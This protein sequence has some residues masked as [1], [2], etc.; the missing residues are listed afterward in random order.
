MIKNLGQRLFFMIKPASLLIYFL[1][2]LISSCDQIEEKKVNIKV[3]TELT[4]ANPF[5]L[6]EEWD[7]YG[8]GD[9]YVLRHNGMYYLYVSTKDFR[10]GIKAWSSKDLMDWTYEGLVTEDVRTT[11]AY[12]PEVMYWNGIFYMYTSPGGQ[13]HYV[14]TSESP[15][16]PFVVKSENLGMSIDGSVF[17][18]DDGTWYFTHAGDQGIV[19]HK[20]VNPFTFDFAVNTNAFMGHWTEG[21]M[22]IKKNNH[23]FMTYTGNHVFSKG[24]RINYAVSDESPLEGYSIPENNPI[25]INT[26]DDFFGLGHNS[27]VLG[28]DLDSYYAIYHNLLGSSAEGPPVRKMNID[29]IIFNGKRMDVLGP[30][31]FEMPAPNKPDYETRW[32]EEKQEMNNDIWL[33]ELKS[34]SQF[35]A[36]YN[37]K[38]EEFINEGYLGSIFSYKDEDNF[39]Y[40]TI[41]FPQKKIALNQVKDG[42][43]LV[44]AEGDIP[45]EFDFTKLHSIRLENSKDTTIV[46]L[47]GM[48][49]ITL[50]STKFSGGKIGYITE[51]VKPNLEYTAFSNVVNSSSDFEAYKPI[52]GSIEAIHYLEGENRG[53]YVKKPKL[54]S[55][56]R[57]KVSIKSNEQNTYSV[58]LKDKGDWLKY[59]VN[60]KEDSLYEISAVIR[61]D[62]IHENSSLSFSID[63]EKEQSFKIPKTNHDGN[64]VK[65]RLGSM[66]IDKGFHVL[67]VL[68][69]SGQIDF[70]RLEIYPVSDNPFNLDH[71]LNHVGIDDIHGS[72]EFV[73]DGYRSNGNEDMKMYI[74]ESYWNDLDVDLTF[75]INDDLMD[76]AGLLLRVTNESNFE[77]QVKDSMMGYY[78]SFNPREVALQKLN[79]D[80]TIIK[81]ASASFASMEEH[82]LHVIIQGSEIKIFVN[83]EKDPIISYNDPNGFMF[84]KVGIRSE[85]SDINFKN[86]KIKSISNNY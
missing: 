40:V 24:Y 51:N 9:P 75:E 69:K 59:K 70:E 55:P 30:T 5:T 16:G 12:A 2:I 31:N 36:E 77:H 48:K 71:A 38:I 18:D 6:P 32:S 37:F 56:I 15:T 50:G 28:P 68:L 1:L 34:E 74:G 73:E 41:Q 46:Y 63:G 10:P 80:S 49:K 64:T 54:S 29:R 57:N 7:D 3:D 61:T 47:D 26:D 85:Y 58:E 79:Y 86:L 62:S 17:I 76:E 81:S 44:L 23:Y 60:V 45:D 11:S 72:W 52:P 83:N 82:Y 27:I 14:L 65:V 53:F 25:I 22:I 84:G 39:G 4:Y 78:I 19:G 20:M 67:K 43:V 13:G 35:T 66:K 42:E 33:S 8:I 21:S